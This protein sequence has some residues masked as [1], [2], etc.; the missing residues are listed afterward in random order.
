MTEQQKN[1]V[2]I[3]GVFVVFVAFLYGG[4]LVMDGLT[5]HAP[6]EWPEESN[7]IQPVLVAPVVTPPAP[8]THTDAGLPI[9]PA[10]QTTPQSTV[11]NVDSCPAGC[12]SCPL[13]SDGGATTTVP[14]GDVRRF[15][16]RRR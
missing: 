3:L 5:Y 2:A 1:N 10:P 11:G 16:G 8:D 13:A 15:F 14:A 4:Y 9:T 6:I 7:G 12:N